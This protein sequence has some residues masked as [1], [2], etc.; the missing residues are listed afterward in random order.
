VRAMR[1]EEKKH[2]SGYPGWG[3]MTWVQHLEVVENPIDHFCR[4][5]SRQ[6]QLYGPSHAC[7]PELGNLDEWECD[8]RGLSYGESDALFCCPTFDQCDWGACKTCTG[9]HSKLPGRG[10]ATHELRQWKGPRQ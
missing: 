8:V 3:N 5:C 9:P 6:L 10:A 4:I 2:T 7:F 1:P